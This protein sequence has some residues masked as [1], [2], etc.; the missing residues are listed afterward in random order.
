MQKTFFSALVIGDACIDE[1]RLGTVTRLNPE[2]PVPILNV[3]RQEQKYGMAFNVANN[4]KAFNVGV[5]IVTPETLS[6]KTRYIDEKTGYQLLRV[7]QDSVA[8]E[9]Q[10]KDSYEYDVIVVSDYDKGFIASD[11][12]GKLSKNFNGLIFVDTKKKDLASYPNVYYKINDVESKALN[13][14]PENLIITKGAD[15]S[16]YK[17]R[18][19]P[20]V[21]IDVVDVCG[22]GDVF[23]AALVY[24]YLE[25]KSIP[26]AIRLANKCAAISCKH[27]GAYTLTRQDIECVF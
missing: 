18:M 12:V 9:Y 7:D 25:H 21:D 22:A 11:T 3:T 2:A 16:V 6:K 17:N 13:S 26:A 27:L 5:K 15:G 24:G 20:G 19:Y 10:V 1:Y 23:L 8:E 14:T 4:L